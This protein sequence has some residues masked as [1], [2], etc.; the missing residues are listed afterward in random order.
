MYIATYLNSGKVNS[1][2][3][4]RYYNLSSESFC[5]QRWLCATDSA[6][7]N[8][9]SD[10]LIHRYM[11]GLQWWHYFLCQ[12]VYC[13][14]HVYCLLTLLLHTSGLELRVWSIISIDACII[15]CTCFI[16][17]AWLV[18][19]I[20]CKCENQKSM[21]GFERKLHWQVCNL[22]SNWLRTL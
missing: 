20:E 10:V 7:K 13:T 19:Q 15:F 3:E 18:S 4:W 21:G 9:Q 1:L 22:V 12:L 2:R 17:S 6:N 16:S 8:H 5:W 11:P 14:M